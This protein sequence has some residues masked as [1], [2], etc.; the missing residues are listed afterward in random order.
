V[1]GGGAEDGVYYL[2]QVAVGDAGVGVALG[3][4]L[5]LLGHLQAAGDAARRLGQNGAVGG[6][7]APLDG[8]AAAVEELQGHAVLA[9]D[10][11]QV[12]LGLVQLPVGGQVAG[13]LVAV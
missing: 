10:L 5:A 4:D 3:Y 11:H 8:A 9:A 2:R 12:P 6:A 7:A 1:G 13:L